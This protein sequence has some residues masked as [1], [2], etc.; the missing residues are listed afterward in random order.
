M[1]VGAFG[2]RVSQSCR[3]VVVLISIDLF[4]LCVFF[5]QSGE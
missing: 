4:I 1:I 5:R 3:R 2:C